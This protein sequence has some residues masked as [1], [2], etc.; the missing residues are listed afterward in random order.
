[1]RRLATGT[2]TLVVV[3][4]ALG[5]AQAPA[6]DS[7]PVSEATA[8]AV[9]FWGGTPCGGDVAVVAGP[10]DEAPPAGENDGAATAELRAAMWATWQS[11]AGA[12][13]FLAPAAT[14]SNCTVHVSPA[15]WPTW[16]SDDEEFAAFCKEMLHEYGHFEGHPDVGA[17]PYT[18]EYE[19]PVLAHAQVCESFHL[20]YGTELYTAVKP[21]GERLSVGRTQQSRRRRRPRPHR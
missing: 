17:I 19:Q 11:P 4:V 2:M 10:L 1:M 20:V 9:E 13:E 14:F 16:R 8:R 12:N 3:V 18:I 6:R 15:V 7:D 5:A 21:R